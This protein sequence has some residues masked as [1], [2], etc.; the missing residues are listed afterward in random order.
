MTKVTPENVVALIEGG[1]SIVIAAGTAISTARAFIKKWKAQTAKERIEVLESYALRVVQA[2]EQNKN[3]VPSDKK[4]QAKQKLLDYIGDSPLK[5]QASISQVDDLI[6]AAVN[7][8]KDNKSKGAV[9][10]STA[11][12]SSDDNV[13]KNTTSAVEDDVANIDL[14]DVDIDL[15]GAE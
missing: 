5:L 4:A 3:L 9:V 15:S 10:D 14:S 2:V 11:T 1:L 6:E 13:E 12:V 7:T 8:L